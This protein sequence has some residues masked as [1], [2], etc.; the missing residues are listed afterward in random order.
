MQP[1]LD[2]FVQKGKFLHV[3]FLQFPRIFPALS[4]RVNISEILRKITVGPIIRAW[5][6]LGLEYNY[7]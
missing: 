5:E 3:M 2:I 4:P 1:D 7:G 6:K